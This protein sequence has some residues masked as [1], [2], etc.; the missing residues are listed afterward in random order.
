MPWRHSFALRGGIAGCSAMRE[1]SQWVGMSPNMLLQT[2]LSRMRSS[3]GSS[4]GNFKERVRAVRAKRQAVSRYPIS[5]SSVIEC[6]RL[7]DNQPIS[8]DISGVDHTYHS[9][10]IGVHA[11]SLPKVQKG[12]VAHPLSVFKLQAEA[13]CMCGPRSAICAIAIRSKKLHQ[14]QKNGKFMH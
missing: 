1:G 11:P 5:S 7:D 8:L 4:R 12:V 2:T 3:T 9:K 6:T 10:V 13:F 14:N